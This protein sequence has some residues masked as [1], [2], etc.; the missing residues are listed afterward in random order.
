MYVDASTAS[1]IEMS[2]LA[3]SCTGHID[4]AAS[5]AAMDEVAGAL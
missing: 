2:T 1:Q 3:A 5:H 4:A